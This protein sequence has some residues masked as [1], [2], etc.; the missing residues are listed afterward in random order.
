MVEDATLE[1]CFP[2]FVA[3]NALRKAKK[4]AK[5]SVTAESIDIEP[6][7]LLAATVQVAK[8]QT[9]QPTTIPAVVDDSETESDPELQDNL[10]ALREAG[11]DIEKKREILKRI[12][13]LHIEGGGFVH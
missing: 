12:E 3:W 1:R 4:A 5:T 10:K 6:D 7:P 11:S 9:E 8:S 2:E 13:Q